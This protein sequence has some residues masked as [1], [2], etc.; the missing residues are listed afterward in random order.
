MKIDQV[1]VIPI[2]MPNRV[3][4]KLSTVL[5]EFQENVIVR[6]RAGGITGIGETEPL[7]GF[8]GCAESQSTIVHMIRERFAPLLLGRDPFDTERI[9]RDLENAVWGNPYAKAGVINALYDLMAKTLKMPLCQLLGGRYREKIPVV[10]TIGIK[11]SKEMAQEALGA[12]ERGYRL[13]KLKIGAAAPEV[14]VQNVAAIR[15]AVGPDI[16]LRVDANGALGFSQALKLLRMLAP[17]DLELVEQPLPIGDLDGMARLIEVSGVPIMPDESLHSPES[18]LELVARKAASIFGMKLAKHGGIYHAQ[19]IAAIAQAAH[20][21]IYPGNQPGT[22]VGSA[23]AA[24]FFAAT[25][26]A[27]L[28]GDFNVGP[29]GWL[30]DDIVKNPLLVRDG[31]A[32]V[33]QGI[34]IGIE[35]DDDKL[36]KYAVG[37]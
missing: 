25:W 1:E 6:L 23:T 19:K 17:F 35:L 4:M 13:L 5:L 37:I 16:G 9:V 12:L 31:Y 24:H 20:L 21:P 8:Q 29:T 22:S 36:A 10:W 15:A 27:T 34:G 28:G 3:P 11:D 26:N 7:R 33:P 30:A 18:A 32:F 14:D 2:R